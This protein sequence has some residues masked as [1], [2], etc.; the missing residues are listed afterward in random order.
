MNSD[1]PQSIILSKVNPIA[2]KHRVGET[3]Q[4]EGVTYR[5]TEGGSKSG[6]NLREVS[7]IPERALPVH[8]WHQVDLNHKTEIVTKT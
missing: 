1:V 7:F 5:L 6:G 2:L 4:C 3:G 8:R